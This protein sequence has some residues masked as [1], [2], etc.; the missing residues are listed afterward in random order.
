VS[1]IWNWSKEA[2]VSANHE[3][4]K[5]KLRMFLELQNEAV[6]PSITNFQHKIRQ[7]NGDLKSLFALLFL[8]QDN[9]G[10]RS[11]EKKVK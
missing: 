4:F 5:L 10:N 1:V 3:M 2:Q 8:A 9:G 7:G 11:E 6:S